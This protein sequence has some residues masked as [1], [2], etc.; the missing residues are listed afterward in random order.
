[1]DNKN[2]AV[3]A[4]Q[5]DGTIQI[6]LTIPQ[7]EVS[8]V[9]SEVVVELARDVEVAGFRKGQAPLEEA[10]KKIPTQVV[11]ERIL[12]KVLPSAYNKA[13]AENSIKPFLS[14]RFELI[15]VS[16]DVDWQIRAITCEAPQVTVGD[17]QKEVAAAQRTSNLWVPGKDKK[18]PTLEEK[19]NLVLE[20]LLKTSK[21][22]IPAPLIEEEVAHRLSQL[23][24]QTQKLGLTVEQYLASTG[25]TVDQLKAEYKLQADAQIKSMLILS[26]IAEK[27]GIKIGE[28]DINKVINPNGE[29]A[30]QPPSEAQ[31]EVLKSILARRAALDKLVA[32]I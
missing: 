13:V 29:I 12:S 20:T 5:E 17:Y 26:Q 1:M 19:E 4:R 3:V 11:V 18:E 8:R 30:K 10:R 28:E 16:T 22:T 14:P 21:V 7:T 27:E 24:D 31:K 23:I 9:E 15:N 25:K 2:K 6:T 32:A